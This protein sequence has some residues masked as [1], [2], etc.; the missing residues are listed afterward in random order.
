MNEIVFVNGCFDAPLHVGHLN[1]LKFAAGYGPVHVAINSDTSIRR[2][3]GP[4]RPIVPENQRREMLLAIRYVTSVFIFQG[5]DPLAELEARTPSILIVGPDHS[6][7]SKMCEYV[8]SYGGKV[9]RY[10]GPKH[11]GTSELIRRIASCQP[12]S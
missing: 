12:A 11:L 6:L 4:A 10:Y 1:L 9:I 3:K 5:D 2:L 7:D 8:R